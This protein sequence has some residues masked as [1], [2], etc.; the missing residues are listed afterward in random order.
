MQTN[1]RISHTHC[2]NKLKWVDDS[3]FF[4]S[5]M[6]DIRQNPKIPNNQT[7]NSI[8]FLKFSSIF[9]TTRQNIGEQK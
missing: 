4:G 7:Q 9:S 6:T 8:S 2:H 5:K 3:S 1:H